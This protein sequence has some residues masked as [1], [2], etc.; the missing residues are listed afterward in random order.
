[1]SVKRGV[2]QHTEGIE[3]YDGEIIQNVSSEGYKYL[4]ITE[5]GNIKHTLMKEKLS[6]EYSR[7]VKK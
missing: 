7:S 5:Q 3:M 2:V 6:K 4:G 1:M